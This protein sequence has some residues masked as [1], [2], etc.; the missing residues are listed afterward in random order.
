M[1]GCLLIACTGPAEEDPINGNEAVKIALEDLAVDE[2]NVASI[3]VHEGTY[4]GI[5]CY[6]VYITTKNAAKTYVIDMFQG[7]IL[8]VLDG[9]GH[10]H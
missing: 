9:V 4:E 2:A 3:H 8:A 6:N 10:S 1:V 7:E 5:G